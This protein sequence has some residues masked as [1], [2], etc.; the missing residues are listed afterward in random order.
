MLFKITA[1][2]M[3]STLIISLS[4][5]NNSI[6]TETTVAETI[7]ETTIP[8]ETEP[9]PSDDAKE[10][11]SVHELNAPQKFN[12]GDATGTWRKA[13]TASNEL[14][15]DYAAEYASLLMDPADK[16]AIH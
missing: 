1:F 15:E 10:F 6:P 12:Q 11:L 13:P 7:E 9:P 3:C 16:D 2:V 14:V 5:C 4:G 8:V